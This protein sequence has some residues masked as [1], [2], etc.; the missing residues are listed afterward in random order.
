MD[1][2]EIK[3]FELWRMIFGDAPPEYFIEV[4]FRGLALYLF[5][6]FIMR[7]L[8]KRMAGELTVVE[9]VLMVTLGSSVAVAIQVPEGGVLLGFVVLTCAFLFER[10]VSTLTVKSRR[11]EKL[12]Q[13]E[14]DVL[15]KDGVLQLDKMKDTR[16]TPQQLFA[17]L[18]SEDIYQ[19]GKV[20]R[21]YIEAS[22]DF[23]IY[24]VAGEAPAGLPI[25]PPGDDEMT[26]LQKQAR[27]KACTDC[28]LTAEQD[29]EGPCTHC[30]S[31]NWTQAVF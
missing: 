27:K 12:T 19:L 22:G 17:A 10:G 9:M 24:K 1:K 3:P 20:E 5:M 4:F 18:R 29:H 31:Q 8:G 14:A 11:F 16:I 7:W 15:V 21:L 28:G 13:G 2:E 6:L 23:S 26:G 30:H 25:F